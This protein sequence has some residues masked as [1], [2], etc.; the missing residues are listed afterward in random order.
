MGVIVPP[1]PVLQRITIYMT[2][3]TYMKELLK[4]FVVAGDPDRTLILYS[5]SMRV[6]SA[7]FAR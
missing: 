1:D 7:S 4:Q 6:Y 3:I 5:Y 2:I